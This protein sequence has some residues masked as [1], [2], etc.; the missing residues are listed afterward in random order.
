MSKGT[1]DVRINSKIILTVEYDYKIT[2]GEQVIDYENVFLGRYE[3][4]E[5]INEET[6]EIIDKAIEKHEQD[7]N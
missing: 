4:S 2:F 6:M 5:I 7:N 1:I 3:I